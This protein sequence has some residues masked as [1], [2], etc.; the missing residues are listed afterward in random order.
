MQKYILSALSGM[1]GVVVFGSLL[2]CAFVI[3]DINNFYDESLSQMEDFKVGFLVCFEVK[4]TAKTCIENNL[5]LTMK[6]KKLRM[7]R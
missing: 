7:I 2:W 1:S 3:N 5:M 4:E 6:Q